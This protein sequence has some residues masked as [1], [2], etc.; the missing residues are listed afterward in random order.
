MQLTKLNYAH[1]PHLLSHYPFHPFDRHRDI[2]CVSRCASSAPPSREGMVP[3]TQSSDRLQPLSPFRIRRIYILRY[4]DRTIH[5]PES[6]LPSYC[7]SPY[8]DLLMACTLPRESLFLELQRE[9]R[10][11]R[12]RNF[13]IAHDDSLHR[14]PP[15]TTFRTPSDRLLVLQML[16]STSP[17]DVNLHLRVMYFF[18][19]TNVSQYTCGAFWFSGGACGAA[20]ENKIF[21][22]VKVVFR[23]I[24]FFEIV[25]HRIRCF[26]FC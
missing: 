22:H 9:A 18:G 23:R 6:K 4:E 19:R 26:S 5:S 10:L 1:L 25:R 13:W 11:H 3:R 8:M 17:G 20:V 24:Q 21:I 16:E 12:R 2:S 14:T 15:S 7:R